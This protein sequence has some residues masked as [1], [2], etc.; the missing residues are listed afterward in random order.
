MRSSKIYFKHIQV[1]EKIRNGNTVQSIIMNIKQKD[2]LTVN[3]VWWMK[4]GNRKLQLIWL[5]TGW[6]QLI[7]FVLVLFKKLW[8]FI[9][10]WNHADTMVSNSCKACG[11]SFYDDFTASYCS[12]QCEFLAFTTKR[13]FYAKKDLRWWLKKKFHQLFWPRTL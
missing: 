7:D 2:A 5:N 1:L 10:F 9:Q 12:F 13:R 6:S 8:C 4:I 11:R 3:I